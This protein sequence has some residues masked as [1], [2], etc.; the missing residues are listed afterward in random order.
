[1][2]GQLARSAMELV[3]NAAAAGMD[4]PWELLNLSPREIQL[5]LRAHCA[6]M[7][8]LRQNTG[9]LAWLTGRYVLAAFH[10]PRRYPRRPDGFTQVRRAMNDEEMKRVFC[11][12]A[13]Q[14]R[15]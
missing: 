12:L 4:K 14:R 13:Q 15:E 6:R 7:E 9:L 1:M 2:K 5:Q 11:A 10:A 8:M 3:E